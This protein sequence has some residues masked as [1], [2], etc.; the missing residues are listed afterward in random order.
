MPR[1]TA[2]FLAIGEKSGLEGDH[3]AKNG[4]REYL[5]GYVTSDPA[6]SA[7]YTA[8][9]ARDPQQERIAFEGFVDFAIAK[10]QQDPGM[11]IYHFAPY[12]PT[13]LK[14][15]M[16][17]HASREIFDRLLRSER[18]VDLHTV[19]KRSVRASVER[20]SLKDLESF[21]R[22]KRT[23]DLRRASACRRAIEWALEFGH[24]D[25]AFTEHGAHVER[26]NEEDCLSAKALRD[27]L[28]N[29]RRE[30]LDNGHSLPHPALKSGDASERV[31]ER[32]QQILE[33]RTKLLDGI[34]E[35]P[36]ERTPEQQA[37]WL[38]AHLLEWH[39][40]E[41]KP[42][43]WEYFRLRDLMDEDLIHENAALVGLRFETTV[44]GTA[45]CPVHRYRFPD[46]DHDI[47]PDDELYTSGELKVGV[48]Q[49]LDL[50]NNLVDIRKTAASAHV[51]AKSVFAHRHVRAGLW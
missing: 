9:W 32:D 14:R 12:E 28:E 46:Q 11:H 37:Q 10:W 45:T 51:H 38:M 3:F 5:I 7:K 22:F 20:Y 1:D 43:W 35:E 18:F 40:R 4:G 47:R 21:H 41:D 23:E 34:S 13:A 17:R 15:L 24:L 31:Q 2:F 30:V 50:T 26:Y 44:G 42:V 16:S 39:R 8:I 19:L 27:W 29:L 25:Q 33:L 48:V 6:G 49:E 36:S